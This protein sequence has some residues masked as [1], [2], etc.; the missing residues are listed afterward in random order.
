MGGH[1]FPKIPCGLT[2]WW[3]RVD[4]MAQRSGGHGFRRFHMAVR[5]EIF[6]V[7]EEQPR[8]GF[9]LNSQSHSGLHVFC[10]FL[11]C[12]AT[13]TSALALDPIY[14]KPIS[15]LVVCTR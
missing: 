12:L 9:R 4:Y 3:S 11:I 2:S 6:T 14:H 8:S 5:T 7:I 10:M 1:D 15:E 13:I